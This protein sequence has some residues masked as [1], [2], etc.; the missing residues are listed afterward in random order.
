VIDEINGTP[1][2]QKH[3]EERFHRVPK[4]RKAGRPELHDQPGLALARKSFRKAL[5]DSQFA[6]LG[7][8][9]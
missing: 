7:I 9:L 4:P 2:A 3:R 6:S 5:K 8:N 1:K